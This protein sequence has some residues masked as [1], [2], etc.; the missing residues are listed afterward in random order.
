MM[1]NKKK[2]TAVVAVATV[3]SVSTMANPIVMNAQDVVHEE[4]SQS[5]ERKEAPE[6]IPPQDLKAKAGTPLKEIKLPE[7]WA[8][9]DEST[10][11]SV[12]TTTYPAYVTVDDETYDYVKVEGYNAE[13]H[14]VGVKLSVTVETLKEEPAPAPILKSPLS[15]GAIP[16]PYALDDVEI[17][18]TN[19]PDAAF[20]KYLE[21]N[22]DINPDGNDTLSAAEVA[23]ITTINVSSDKDITDLTGIEK[24]PNLK[25]L[26]C[27][28]TSITSLDVSSNTKLE[29]LWCHSNTNLTTLTVSG[30]AA[31]KTLHCYD[32]GVASLDVSSNTNLSTL[33]C[34]S[35]TNLTT[36][37]VSGAAALKSLSCNGTS[38][39]RLD[40][41][42]NTKLETLWCHSNTNLT[43]LTVSGAAALK[44]LSCNGTGIARLDVSN[45]TNLT[46]L[47][48]SSN[49]NLT[50]LT[51]SGAAALNELDC[52]KTG[53]ASLDVSSNTNLTTL[54]CS[55][56]TNLTTLTVSGAAALT[57]LNCSSNTNLKTL[58][59][60]GVAA[61]TYLNCSSN[62]NLKTLTVS[63]AA[64]LKTLHCSLTG[65]ASLDVSSNTKLENLYCQNNTHLKTLTVS[66]ATA[67]KALN[68]SGTSI[69]SLDVSNNT[70]LTT[71]NCSTTPLA[72]LNLGTNAGLTSLTMPTPRTRY[73]E[74]TED[75][76]SIEDKIAGIDKSKVSITSGAT[77][78]LGNG[79]VSDYKA[80][81]PI[82]YV[83]DCG[84]A[85]SE[86]KTLQVT[87]NLTGLKSESTI[88]V[89][90]TLD[91]TYDGTAVDSAPAVKKSGSTGAVTYTWEKKN[92][93]EWESIA[94][95]PTIAGTYRVT[96][97][98]AADDDYKSAKSTKEFTIS[99]ADSSISVTES[100]DKTYNGTAVNSAPAVSKSGSTGVVTYTW[101]KK[102]NATE[103]ESIANAPTIAGTYRVTATVAADDNYKSAKSTKEFTISKADSSISVTESLD[104][105]YN[106]TAVNSAPAVS[107]SGS[108][109]VVTYT[110][111]KKKNATEWESIAVAPTV[112]GTYRV[113]ATVAA[114]DNYKSAKSTKEFTISKADST[115]SVTESLN[116]DYDG[117]AVNS[118]PTVEK[119]GSTGTVTYAW[120]KKKNATEWESISAAPTDAGT[121]H[122]T[123]TVAADGNY[124]QA[125]STAKEFS[126]SQAVN[127]WTSTLAITGWTYG[128]TANAPA[129]VAAFGSVSYTY[130]S[131]ASGTYTK[132]V[133]TDAG[134]WYVKATV[135]GT[136]N[137]KGIESSAVEFTIAKAAAPAMTL[138]DN[139][140]GVYDE[141]L[142]SVTLPDGWA[143]ADETQKLI[144]S[145]TDYPAHFTVDD[146][147]YDYTGV[148]GYDSTG[149]YVECMLPVIVSAAAN[150]WTVEPAIENWTY[151][152]TASIPTAD[153]AYG[154][155]VFSY[156]DTKNG[157]YTADRPTTA[158]T[159]YMKA[160]VNAT[161]VYTGLDTIVK[162]TISQAEPGYTAP[163]D[164]QAVY[165]QSLKDIT[166]STGFA[167]TDQTLDVGNAGT[168]EF[169]LTYTPENDN[170][171][172][173]TDIKVTVTVTKAKNEQATPISLEGWT[174]GAAPSA[175]RAGFR[176]GQ[177]RF[178]YSDRMA[179]TYTDTV[180]TAAGTWY[181]KA[182]VDGTD[183][184]EGAESEVASF[185][186]EPKS[187]E[188]GNQIKV[189]EMSTDTRLDDLVIKDGDKVLV[190]GMD[191][192]VTQIQ[193]GNKVVVTITFK[194]NYTGTVVQAYT[195][196]KK[197]K[198]MLTD[199]SDMQKESDKKDTISN[200][201][202]ETVPTGDTTAKGIW[203]LFMLFAA[204]V[205]AFMRKR[206]VKK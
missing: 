153:A 114:D 12:D 4:S 13:G 166:L 142:S 29:T 106:G 201:N 36:L 134:T 53:I 205:G 27:Y 99:K 190:Q 8:W 94:T 178:L 204:G 6:I 104:K 14:Y 11:L 65:I 50:T 200:A 115:I 161:T 128:Q 162:F 110:W 180:P 146:K 151:N 64:A 126:I 81:T 187:V 196:E 87:L 47:D 131:K 182:V 129:A 132:N 92:A 68:C 86:A 119:T 135:T 21:E 199:S 54:D 177:P 70:N 45:N 168:N 147:N 59:I 15:R 163:K 150:S 82:V 123:A 181:V 198:D 179:G 24:F 102:K 157:T 33:N 78:N 55:S 19:F 127:S 183:N 185:V 125:S 174:Y 171:K 57:Y 84:T 95:A 71:L 154:D 10:V 2:Q 145:G 165:G 124:K 120:E 194:G 35:N 159:W 197:D 91:K 203:T 97:T 37:T 41:S 113:T 152:E 1:S 40:V 172:I 192:D 112:A 100:L 74:V 26:Y 32:I 175:V 17:N 188:T 186:I 48:C 39:A 160:S 138:P 130:S 170:Y 75:T 79:V 109:G 73:L 193:D 22:S 66:G 139:L 164:L 101:E 173:M 88:S 63:D 118:T 184:Y 141:D 28:N 156:S 52:Q 5:Y 90:A 93:T 143:W 167:W 61:L 195:S 85:N 76:F 16:T 107:K 51:V 62:T 7:N 60:S 108:T 140:S 98:V 136:D 46:T 9:A 30:A 206:F 158:G 149:H 148:T 122:V 58:T 202:L 116:K 69:A 67:L 121:Y 189:P 169:T 89:T 43:T 38:I 133:P 155:V 83:Y 105:T 23:S 80:G 96:A 20:R 191:Y 3:L 18:E 49:T 144:V 44:T 72:Y 117:S 42:S 56:N 77:Y 111:E 176:F 34:Y 31:L 103:W 137:F 25:T